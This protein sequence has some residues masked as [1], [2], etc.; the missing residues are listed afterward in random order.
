MVKTTIGFYYT[1]IEKGG[2][3]EELLHLYKVE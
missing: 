2:K 3:V 1:G